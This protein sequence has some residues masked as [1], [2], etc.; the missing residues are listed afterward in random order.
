MDVDSAVLS[1]VDLVVSHDGVAVCAYL[2]A[3][4]GVPVDVVV[5]DETA[6]LAKYVHSALVAIVDLVS[7]YG[8]VTAGGDPHSGKIV[9]VD[10]VVDEL[11]QARLVY[12]DAARLAV[13]YLAVHHCG[14]G[15][16]LH[17][18]AG[19]PVVMN[20]I[21]FKVPLKNN[22]IYVFKNT[23]LNHGKYRGQQ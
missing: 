9:G 19:Y 22:I 1:M 23:S 15:A 18:E 6:A 17:L 3:G 5:L 7:A 11:S 16:G 8:G 10:L 20:V 21:G 13:V 12:V 14:V 4:K 2:Y